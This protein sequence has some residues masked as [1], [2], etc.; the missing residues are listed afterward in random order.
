MI[1][2]LLFYVVVIILFDSVHLL[3]LFSFSS[4]LPLLIRIMKACTNIYKNW[5]FHIE[6]SELISI[7]H[8]HFSLEAP[9]WC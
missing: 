8:L 6:F 5:V 1:Q 3:V 2:L 9:L 7:L 4:I